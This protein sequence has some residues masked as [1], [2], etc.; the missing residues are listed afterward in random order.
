MGCYFS[1]NVLDAVER[2]ADKYWLLRETACF[3]DGRIDG[4]LIP[5]AY[6]AHCI[7]KSR[8]H[9]ASGVRVCGVEV[10][11]NR[12][13]FLKGK[14]SGQFTRYAKSLAGLYIA[15]PYELCKTSEIPDDC[16]HLVVTNRL[17][18]TGGGLGFTCVCKRHPKYRDVQFDHR[19]MWELFFRFRDH[20][21]QREYELKSQYREKL[22]RIGDIAGKKVFAAIREIE[23]SVSTGGE[24]DAESL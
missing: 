14:K 3:V 2:W 11:V 18:G 6:D 10:K 16:G 23:K 1:R 7:K 15:T 17:S 8:G 21:V 9:Y 12:S 5:T 20:S 13:D 4:L 22:D 19:Q 24:R